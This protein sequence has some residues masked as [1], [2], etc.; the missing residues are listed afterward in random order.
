VKAARLLSLLLLLQTH[1][2]TTTY[3]LAERLEV[4]RRTVLRDIEALSVA[5][6][7]VYA[8]RGRHGGIALLPG[9]RL[10]LSQL[11]PAELDSLALT[12]LDPRQRDE[13][14]LAATA[15]LVDRKLA[16][17]R[18]R[19][20]S[21]EP[22]LS[23]L[24]IVDNSSW[25]AA[26]RNEG[27]SPADLALDL[28]AKRRWRLRYRH[29][30]TAQLVTRTVDPYG[31]AARAGRWYLVADH[32]G[33]PALYSL[34]RLVRHTV[35]PEAAR[36]RSGHDL[37]TVWQE[38]SQR[39][40]APGRV[41]VTARL[42]AGRVDLARRVLGSRLVSVGSPVAG[43]CPIELAYDQVE[44]VRQLLQFGDHIE[45]T[46]PS[47]ARRRLHELALDLAQRHTD[48]SGRPGSSSP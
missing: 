29:S 28:R 46:G 21:V 5:G 10:N 16:A 7:P 19:D 41:R 33:R 38:L 34:A 15:R 23:D 27:T 40:E 31:L 13:L 35:L 44:A 17:R 47:A 20:P 6:I 48:Q 22:L 2:R 43:W 42:R 24:V 18:A 39:V 26:D 30:G 14:G 36:Q 37:R 9:A 45:V 12:G 8:E 3:E 11:D 32:R 25:F 1:P 4:S